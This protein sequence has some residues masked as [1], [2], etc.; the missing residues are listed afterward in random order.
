ML[1]LGCRSHWLAD[2]W[3]EGFP[4]GEHAMQDHGELAR[5]RHLGLFMPA[6]LAS[7]IAQL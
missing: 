4:I 6:R 1:S 5:Q 7:R 2:G 3:V